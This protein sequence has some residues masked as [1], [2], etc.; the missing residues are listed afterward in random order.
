MKRFEV[1][2][3]GITPLLH[4]RMTEEALFS[5]LG[6]KAKKKTTAEAR[7]P[8]E[9]AE[10]HAYKTSDGHYYI[11]LTYVSGAFAHVASDYKQSNSQR[12]SYKAIAGG[13]F[14]PDG[15][16]A[17]L[18]DPE[19]GSKISS[20]EVDIRKATNH[21]AGAVAVCRPRFDRWSCKFHVTVN[22][23][24]LPPDTALQ[25]LNDAGLRSGIGSFRVS[26]GGYFGQFAVQ[27]FE[28]LKA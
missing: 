18:L 9:I 1:T 4:H 22:D 26:N 17:V 5:L 8:R 10:D 16:A 12:K 23:D 11:P 28:P 13:V 6:T 15:E 14:R 27:C 2:L 7:T 25:I 24:L 21:K 19:T 20:F 3:K